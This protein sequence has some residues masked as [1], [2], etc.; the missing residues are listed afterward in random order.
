MPLIVR[1]RPIGAL[2]TYR[3]G[4]GAEFTDDEFALVRRFADLAALALDNTQNRT[5]CCTRRRRTG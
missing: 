2:N 3:L 4:E 5:S 1:D